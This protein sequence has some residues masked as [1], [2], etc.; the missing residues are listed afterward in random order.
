VLLRQ[1]LNGRVGTVITFSRLIG[2][3][4]LQSC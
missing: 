4:G 1:E 2:L 3:V